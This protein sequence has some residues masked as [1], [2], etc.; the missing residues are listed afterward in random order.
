[1]QTSVLCQRVC[2]QLDASLTRRW[3]SE[4][5]ACPYQLR[6]IHFSLWLNPSTIPLLHDWVHALAIATSSSV[7][8]STKLISSLIPEARTASFQC[9]K[10]LF[11]SGTAVGGSG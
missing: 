1:M 2:E 4:K 9:S 6:L 3:S 11:P 8:P 7:I 10:R 5:P